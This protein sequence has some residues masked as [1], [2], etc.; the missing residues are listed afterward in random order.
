LVSLFT[1]RHHHRILPGTDYRPVKSIAVLGHRHYQRDQ[2]LAISMES[3]AGPA[4]VIIAGILSPA[5]R[6][7]SALRRPPRCYATMV[8][9]LDASVR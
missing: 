7:C 8:V 4:L 6:A 9:A 1:G 2:G 3:T 5:W